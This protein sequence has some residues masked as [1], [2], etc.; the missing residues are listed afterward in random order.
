V[1]ELVD[2]EINQGDIDA[3]RRR[4]EAV[5]MLTRLPITNEA[6]ALAKRLLRVHALPGVA[7]DDAMHVALAAVHETD[8]LLTWNCRHIAN[9]R[10]IPKISATIVEANYEPP[11]ITTPT[12]LLKSP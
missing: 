1:S 7:E 10:M 3:I 6:R 5:A 4:Q 11:L 12:D 8:I 2:D 9:Q